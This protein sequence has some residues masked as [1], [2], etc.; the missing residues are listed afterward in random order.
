MS[1]ITA[2]QKSDQEFAH[3]QTVISV[4]T[5]QNLLRQIHEARRMA[6]RA[7]KRGATAAAEHFSRAAEMDRQTFIWWAARAAEMAAKAF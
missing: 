5:Q 7:A 3:V 6:R 2:D 1:I 4:S